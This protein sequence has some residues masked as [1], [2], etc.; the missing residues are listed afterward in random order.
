M[1]E[2]PRGTHQAME[3]FSG[4]LLEQ[5]QNTSSEVLGGHYP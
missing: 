1:R 3:R 2:L 4:S 5:F